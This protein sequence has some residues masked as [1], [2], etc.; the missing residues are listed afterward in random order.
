MPMAANM[1][2]R[3]CNL[4]MIQ[5]QSEDVSLAM[6]HKTSRKNSWRRE[7][8]QPPTDNSTPTRSSPKSAAR[9]ARHNLP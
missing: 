3:V 2:K 1:A 4:Y 5:K 6:I 8:L 7:V 9:S